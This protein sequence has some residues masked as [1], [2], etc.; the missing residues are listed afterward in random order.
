MLKSSKKFIIIGC[1]SLTT[2]AV[3]SAYGFHGLADKLSPAD[4]ASWGWAVD[5]QFFHSLGLI[6]IALLNMKLRGSRLLNLAS[7]L[8]VLG[9]VIFCGSIYAEK[10]GA[11]AALGE[12]A[13]YGGTSFMIAWATVALAVWLTPS[14]NT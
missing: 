13:P 4:Q 10:L 1:L 7:W 5:M 14:D 11:P 2:T 12:I 8:M 6:I 3:L 9:M